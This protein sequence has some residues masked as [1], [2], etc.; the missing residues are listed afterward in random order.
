[1]SWSDEDDRF[2]NEKPKKIH[3]KPR[4]PFG[5]SEQISSETGDE[6]AEY[7]HKRG[8]KRSHRK[9]THKDEFWQGGDPSTY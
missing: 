8:G 4:K 1:M 9:K 6:D 3:R 2:E 5:R 7:R